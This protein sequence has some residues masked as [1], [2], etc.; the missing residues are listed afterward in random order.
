MAL[1]SV[2]ASLLLSVADAQQVLVIIGLVLPVMVV[3]LWPH[4]RRLDDQLLVS[5]ELVGVLRRCPIFMPLTLAQ[6]EQLAGG[7]VQVRFETGAVV[8]AEGH[9]GDA[10]YVI[11]HGHV[12]VSSAGEPVNTMGPGDSFGEIAL[13]RGVPRTATVTATSPLDV[14]RIARIDVRERYHGQP[15]QPCR[16]RGGR[17]THRART[18]RLTEASEPAPRPRARQAPVGIPIAADWGWQVAHQKTRRGSSP[19]TMVLMALPHRGH[20]RPE[21]P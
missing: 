15:H 3:M 2:A 6:L 10:F 16:R 20:G 18:R 14:Y 7:T 19:K 17:G 4:W 1:G 5:R 12:A 21:R 9:A 8:I 11:T 13:V